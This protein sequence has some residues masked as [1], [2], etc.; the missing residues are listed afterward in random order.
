M[1]TRAMTFVALYALLFLAQA[2][3]AADTSGDAKSIE[4][5]RYLVRVSGCNDCHTPGY[6]QGE[7]Q[8]PEATWLTGS[9]VGFKGPWGTT[10]PTNLRR[11]VAGMNETEWLERVRQP[12]R[13]PMPWFNLSAMTDSDLIALYRFISHLGDAGDPAP[14]AAAPGV[15]VDTPYFDFVP[16]NLPKLAKQ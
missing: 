1:K 14:V 15:E 3:T 8:V 2:S 13:P 5:G 7:G 6:L 4:R 16:K 10:Y 9:S 11:A 12:M